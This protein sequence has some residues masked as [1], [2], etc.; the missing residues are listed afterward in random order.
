VFDLGMCRMLFNIVRLTRACYAFSMKRMT[1]PLGST[2]RE[3]G[4]SSQFRE[5]YLIVSFLLS[6][7]LLISYWFGALRIVVCDGRGVGTP[8]GLSSR[9]PGSIPVQS[10]PVAN[11]RNAYIPMKTWVLNSCSEREMG[12]DRWACQLMPRSHLAW[13]CWNHN[14]DNRI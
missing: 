2:C 3:E 11:H 4:Y 7:V 5:E 6:S 12:A 14:A 1:C 8:R 13:S 9:E 10:L